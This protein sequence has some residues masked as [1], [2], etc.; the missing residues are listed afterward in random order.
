MIF[1]RMNKRQGIEGG[2]E[3]EE[4]VCSGPKARAS[5]YVQKAER[6]SGGN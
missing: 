2:E 5:T 4:T 3:A 6:L 1:F